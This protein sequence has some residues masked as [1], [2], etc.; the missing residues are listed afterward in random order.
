MKK[1]IGI[2]LCA[3]AAA[4]A[5]A[6]FAACGDGRLEGLTGS[7]SDGQL[8]LEWSGG[9]LCE[10]LKAD[11]ADGHYTSVCQTRDGSYS[12]AD[13]SAYYMIRSVDGGEQT[14]PYCY[15]AM[16]GDNVHIYTA[17]ASQE[18]IQSDIDRIYKRLIWEEFS[19][20]RH[21]FMFL[22][23]EYDEVTAKAGYYTTFSGLGYSPEDVTLKGLDT[24]ESPLTDNSLVN[25]WRGAENFT[26]TD[27]ATWCVS[28]ATSLRRMNFLGDLALDD[29]GYSSGGFLADSAVAGSIVNNNQQQWFTRNSSFAE[30]RGTDINMV[31]SGVEGDIVGSWPS[32][33]NTVLETTEI[34]REKPFV[35]FDEQQGF[36]VFLPDLRTESKGV[37]WSGGSAAGEFIPIDSFYI[38]DAERDDA[39]SLNAALAEGKHLLFTPGIYAVE[40]PL[41]ITYGRTV[42]LGL[43]LATLQT[44]EDN[45]DCCVRI[46]DV[47]G[48][49]VA[50]LLIDAGGVSDKLMQVGEGNYDFD[51]EDPVC[52]SDLF[53]RL[54]GGRFDDGQGNL[55][56]RTVGAD[57]ALEINSDG[58]VGDNFWLWRADHG[59][60]ADELLPYTD[61]DGGLLPDAVENSGWAFWRNFSVGWKGERYSNYGRNGLVVNGDGVTI[62]GLMVEH[63][64]EYQTLWQGEDGFVCFYQSETPYDAPDQSAWTHDGVNGYASYKV[65]D[66]VTTHR[67]SGLGVYYVCNGTG[68]SMD[69]AVEA[70]AAAGIA[71]YHLAVANFRTNDG[72]G[73]NSIINGQG[74]GVY[75]AGAKTAFTSFVGGVYTP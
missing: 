59:L 37:S 42:V 12:T 70:P 28:Q 63:F 5:V 6:G 45:A 7:F 29:D 74:R 41:Y 20:Q 61:E 57:I 14:Q 53:F 60:S 22:P 38:A 68:I 18:E 23:G 52:L 25:F 43:G 32:K 4:F 67:A 49:C 50:G 72:N 15:L 34:M 69:N 66:G 73:I 3:A 21:A 31:F 10:V 54:G 26:V 35:V 47:P 55:I 58:V 56:E 13:Y 65:A 40:Q 9:G 1:F 11:E 75:A 30:W 62:Y 51:G 2:I 19:L 8:T 44:T 36:G 48:V 24:R 46:A 17:D 39:E 33:R 71:M 16:F 27:D 64:G